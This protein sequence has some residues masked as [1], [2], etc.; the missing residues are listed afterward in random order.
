VK[1]AREDI[2]EF[3]AAAAPPLSK[4]PAPVAFQ[5]RSRKKMRVSRR[6]DVIG[7]T[8]TMH[9]PRRKVC[10]SRLS[11]GLSSV[12]I[13][14]GSGMGILRKACGK[15]AAAPARGLC[16]RAAADEGARGDGVEL[17]V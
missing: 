1:V 12:R 2:A 4:L 6:A 14:H 13:V 15:S 16:R 3:S 8:W 11:A 10:G 17:R 7:E 9:A 5:F